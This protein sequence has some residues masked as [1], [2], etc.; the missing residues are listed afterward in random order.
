MAGDQDQTIFVMIDRPKKQAW[1]VIGEQATMSYENLITW[2]QY[3]GCIL[4]N[5]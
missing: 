2:L 4:L 5:P 1:R 3:H